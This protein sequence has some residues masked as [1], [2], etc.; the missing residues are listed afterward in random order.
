MNQYTPWCRC[1]ASKR[2]LISAKEVKLAP[3]HSAGPTCWAHARI[4]LV[5]PFTLNDMVRLRPPF[6]SITR[7]PYH[8]DMK[9]TARKRETNIVS[10]PHRS[11]TYVRCIFGER[12]CSCSLQYTNTAISLAGGRGK[13]EASS[14]RLHDQ[15]TQTLRGLTMA[16]SYL[17]DQNEDDN[18]T[19]HR[20]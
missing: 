1:S 7:L 20:C 8:I 14:A 15:I 18:E 2:N 12:R 19:E 16:K 11:S 3:V 6:P 9:K 13:R 4:A 17:N 5:T 10:P